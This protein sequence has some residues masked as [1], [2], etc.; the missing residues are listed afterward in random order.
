MQSVTA[1]PPRVPKLRLA[2]QLAA[3]ITALPVPSIV[4]INDLAWCP[5]NSWFRNQKYLP[6]SVKVYVR[7]M[8]GRR[9]L[10]RVN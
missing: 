6:E 4:E 7:R 10:I 1:K 3:R 9:W 8:G 5:S 2:E